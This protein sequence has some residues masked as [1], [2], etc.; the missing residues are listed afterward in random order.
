MYIV[1]RQ[2]LP[3]PHLSVQAAHAAIAATLTFGE[4][5]Q[6]HPHLVLCR[7][8][9]E[10]DLNAL[11]NSLKEQGVPCCAWYEDDLDDSLTALATAPLRG[12]ERKPLR[13]LPLLR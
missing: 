6:S 10:Q 7:A 1:V 8:R 12:P 4:P 9:D 11:F 13:N 3:H 2:D 5:T